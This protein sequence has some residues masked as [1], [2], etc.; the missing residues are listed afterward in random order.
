MNE[1]SSTGGTLI[2]TRGNETISLHV[3]PEAIREKPISVEKVKQNT[4]AALEDL[5]QDI[6]TA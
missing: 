6:Q 2:R 4:R 5:L 1:D 3:P